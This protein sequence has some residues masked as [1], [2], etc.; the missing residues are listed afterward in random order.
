MS[1]ALS[2]RSE[3]LDLRQILVHELYD[4]GAFSHAGGHTLYRAVAHI[5]ND[6]NPWHISFE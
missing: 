4:D 2:V 3:S 6:K 5:A 1:V